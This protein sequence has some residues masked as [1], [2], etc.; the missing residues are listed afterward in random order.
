[1]LP[2]IKVIPGILDYDVLPEEIPVLLREFEKLCLA[3]EK[4]AGYFVIIR[5][6]NNCRSHTN[7]QPDYP[8]Y[9]LRVLYIYLQH[10]HR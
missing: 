6:M 5:K 1:M 8:D 7:N 4:D 2:Y 9:S 3:D 10:L